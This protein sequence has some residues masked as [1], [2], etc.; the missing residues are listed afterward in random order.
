MNVLICVDGSPSLTE[1]IKC[2]VSALRGDVEYTLLYVLTERGVYESYKHIFKEDLERIEAL[3]EDVDSEKK[4][5]RRVFLDPLCTSMR[6]QGLTVRT[7]VREGHA[8]QEIADEARDGRYDVV[9]L[10][11]ARSLSPSKLLM[12]STVT[13]V[14]QN[15]RACV[16]VVRPVLITR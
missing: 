14:M 4:T 8:A 11:G 15:V 12:G 3:F 10:G 6:E 5:A 16:L 2:A 1:G 7:I 9:L 13:E